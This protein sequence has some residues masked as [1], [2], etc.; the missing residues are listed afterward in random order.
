MKILLFVNSSWNVLN[1]RANLVRSLIQEGYEVVILAPSDKYTHRLAALN[2][3]YKELRISPHSVNPFSEIKHLISVFFAVKKEN[4]DAILS[5]TVKPNIYGSISAKILG[6]NLICNIAGLGSSHQNAA[7]RLTIRLVYKYCLKN[8]RKCFFQNP[9]DQRYFVANKIVPQDKAQL[10]PGSGVDTLNFYVSESVRSA[11]GACKEFK[12]LLCCRL[13]KSKGVEDYVLAAEKIKKEFQNVRF[14][15]AGFIIPENKDAIKASEI[16]KWQEDG[17]I[18]YQG[19]TDDVKSALE[20][21]NCF[22]LPTYY[23]EGTP[24]ALLEASAM[25]LPIITTDTPGCRDVVE[26]GVTGFLCK[27]RDHNDLYSKMKKVLELSPRDRQL[28]GRLS[29]TNTVSRYDD[30][31]VSS[32][33]LRVLHNID[34]S[35][36][37]W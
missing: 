6:K 22:V 15:L 35:A 12:F 2:C 31:I 4:P 17:T 1:F 10:L 34:P 21:A 11:R 13:L 3:G 7:L 28:M 14:I 19:S 29:R 27:I 5:F 32:A 9:E 23:N 20:M 25:E 37:L 8:V 18:E 33:Y 30:K 26:D 24:K 16:R 36:S